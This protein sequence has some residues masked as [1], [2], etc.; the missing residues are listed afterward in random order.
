M[1][2][3]KYKAEWHAYLC[4]REVDFV[5]CVPNALPACPAGGM[6]SGFASCGYTF[7]WNLVCCCSTAFLGGSSAD[8]VVGLCVWGV[9]GYEG[10][11][12]G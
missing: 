11:R 10:S 1:E 3:E 12:G 5:L 6:K 2:R 8:W 4:A 7:M 9:A